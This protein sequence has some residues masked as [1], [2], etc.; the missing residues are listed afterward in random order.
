M[1]PILTRLAAHVKASRSTLA[2]GRRAHMADYQEVVQAVRGQL[3]AGTNIS[4]DEL[5]DL[6]TTFAKLCHDANLRLRRCGDY[7]RLGCISEATQLASCQPVLERLIS[8][9]QM[10]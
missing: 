9:L 3:R 2:G 10:P 8:A 7:L 5:A 4:R 1:R 6:A